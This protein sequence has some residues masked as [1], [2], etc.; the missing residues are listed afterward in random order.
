P[1]DLMCTGIGIAT[2][3][4]IEINGILG[5]TQITHI[6][7]GG[8]LPVDFTQ[9]DD[10]PS[11]K[12]FSDFLKQRVPALFTDNFNVITE[13]GRAIAAKNA[14]TIGRVEYTKYMGG[15]PITSCHIGVQTLVRTVYEPEDWKRRVTA[16]NSQGEVK[17]NDLLDQNI[18]GPA[19]FSGDL[20]ARERGLPAVEFGD[21]LMV[22]DTG[23]YHFSSHYQYNAL[24]RIPVYAYEVSNNQVTL[25][26]I[27]AGQTTQDVINDY[28]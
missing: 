11:F 27:S 10:N 3:L 13:Y 1:L 4:A 14:V 7:I 19:C 17:A 9:D 24:P 6:D 22:H 21:Y 28:S 25:E 5:H 16:F 20:I 23:S 18:G 15:V 2:D 12:E 8:G 26:I